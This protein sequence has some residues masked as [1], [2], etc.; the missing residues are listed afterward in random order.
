[1][2]FF[3]VYLMATFCLRTITPSQ[4]R[5]HRRARA[6][7]TGLAQT[8]YW[9]ARA[10][11]QGSAEI[12]HTLQSHHSRDPAFLRRIQEAMTQPWHCTWCRRDVKGSFNNCGFCGTHWQDCVSQQAPTPRAPKSPSRRQPGNW[13]YSGQW[14]TTDHAGQWHGPPR[15][16]SPRQPR[17]SP[18][19]TPKQQNRNP[20]RKA[21]PQEPDWHPDRIDSGVA[22]AAAATP[23]AAEANLKDLVHAVQQMEQPLTQDVSTALLKAQKTVAVDPARQL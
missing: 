22:P 10:A 7:Q 5:R 3:L 9:C 12:H 21:P 15:P 8:P 1:M 14:E 16:K 20:P 18:R 17:K 2:G 23:T 19:R 6:S 13:T 11:S 4:R